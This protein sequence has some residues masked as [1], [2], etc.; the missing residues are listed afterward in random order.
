MFNYVAVMSHGYRGPPDP[1]MIRDYLQPLDVELAEE[2]MD[3]M[4]TVLPTVQFQDPVTGQ[5]T[6]GQG[7]HGGGHG[8]GHGGRGH[9]GGYASGMSHGF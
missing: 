3:A 8:H 9:P 7:G 5:I 4:D 6:G 2:V 1:D